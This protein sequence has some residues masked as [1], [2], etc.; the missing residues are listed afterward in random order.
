MQNPVFFYWHDQPGKELWKKLQISERVL[1]KFYLKKMLDVEHT[2]LLPWKI[3]GLGLQHILPAFGVEH[4]FLPIRGLKER[5][6]ETYRISVGRKGKW[7]SS[8]C[9]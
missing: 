3:K 9:G 5:R 7:Y 6:Q 2:N 8:K 4:S 1:L